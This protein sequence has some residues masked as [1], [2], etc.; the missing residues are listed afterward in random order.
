MSSFVNKLQTVKFPAFQLAGMRA[1]AVVS[2]LYV[3][4][5]MLA[6]IA[7]LR[8]LTLGGFSVDGGTLIYPFT[9][10]LRDMVHKVAG[11]SVARTLIITA[12]AVNMVM[13][14]L[15]WIVGQLPADSQVGP[16]LEF[17]AV[18]SPV[19]RI[20]AASIIA[21][22]ISELIDGETYQAWVNRFGYR[23]QWTRVLTSNAVSVPLDSI[24]FAVIAFGGVLPWA[25]V[26][27][28]ALS[29]IIIKGLVTL[30]SMPWIYLVRGKD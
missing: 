1:I 13:A 8:I 17:V 30:V 16:Q 25:V 22:I 4:A 12:A 18:L 23:M 14:A 21:E 7:S 19:W 26:W 10:T 20:V 29:N 11:I 24:I 9:F 28:I 3:A 6:D 5:Q 27:S 15:F 2:S